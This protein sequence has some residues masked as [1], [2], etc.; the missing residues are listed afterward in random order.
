MAVKTLRLD[1]PKGPIAA[2]YI[3][4]RDND[5]FPEI[6]FV[7]PFATAKSTSAVDRLLRRA[8]SYPG[9]NILI[10]R[11]TLTSLKDSTIAKMRQRI[12]VAFDSENL[13]EAVFRLP[14]VEH[15]VS[16]NPV[17]SIV[18]GIG[19]DRNDLEQ[20]LKSTEYSTV[21]LEEANEISS[22]AHDMVQE[23]S[24]QRI[25]HS[26][27]K[28]YHL[29]MRLALRWSEAAG[30]RLTP[31]DVYQIL[32]DDPR[33]P[34]GQEQLAYEHPMPG[35][36]VVGAIWNPVGNDHTWARYVGVSYPMPKPTPEWVSDNVG[37][38]EVHVDAEELIEDHFEFQAG[39]I[40]KLD[41]GSRS[42]AAKHMPD[43]VKL[44]DGR[45]VPRNQA[46]LIV[47]RY[48]I[49]AFSHENESRDYRNV[50]NTYL[51]T[52]KKMR[53][54]HMHGEVDVREG[55]VFPNFV[56]DFVKV[57]GHV[58]PY[59]GKDRLARS[60]YRVVAGI[61]QG[62]AHATA[63][64]M[65]VYAPQTETLIIFDEYVRN[66]ASAKASAYDAQAMMLP[67]CD[68]TWGYDPAMEARVFDED[69]DKRTIDNYIE[70]LGDNVL[71]GARG[72]AA[73]DEVIQL[74]DIHDSF[75]GAQPMPKLIVFDNCFQVRETLEK[76]TWRMIRHQR[77]NWMVDV[78]DAIK[79][80]VSMVQ[81][82]MVNYQVLAEDSESRLAY[83]ERFKDF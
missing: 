16:G 36:T 12:G 76:L 9:S 55:R 25:Y 56:D 80:M 64:V 81:R 27:Q 45:V 63:I 17:E 78:G 20:V 54:R 48:C 29:C 26:H 21:L 50:E 6:G 49:Y 69:A 70:V 11:A 72:D 53:K 19:L 35:Q 37:V 75:I 79:I 33:N 31:E 34:V 44:I 83:N 18:K 61:D 32:L 22:E 68:H 60:G 73:Y 15:P 65:G 74:L 30:R 67:G 40:V 57:G 14:K 46:S 42:F 77:N 52:N 58:L 71:P 10:A 5:D 38:R 39:S 4:F 23:R 13:Q 47:Q 62:G 2:K 66:G 82:G 41:D 3:D 8:S 7:G 59:P 51:M 28:V 1:P 24:R 43:G